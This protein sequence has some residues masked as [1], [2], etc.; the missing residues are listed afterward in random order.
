MYIIHVWDWIFQGLLFRTKKQACCGSL[1]HPT[2]K[3]LWKKFKFPMI[4]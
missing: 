3:D 1:N 4:V 2:Q